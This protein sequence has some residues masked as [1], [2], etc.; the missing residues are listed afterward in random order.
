MLTFFW[1]IICMCQGVVKNTSGLIACRFFMGICKGEFVPGCAY[2]LSMYYKPHEFQQRFFLLWVAGLVAGAFGGLLAYALYHMHGL[3]RYSGWRWT[4]II[5]GLLS[6]VSALSAKFLI[7]DWPERAKFL[8]SEVKELLKELN[9]CDVGEGAGMDRLNGAAWRRIMS[10]WKIYYLG[11]TVSGYATVLFV[12]S[13]V[14]S[15]GY[16]DI[17]SQAHSI[18]TW[19]VTAVVTMM[20]SFLTDCW[21]HGYGFVIFGVVFASIG[22][23]ILLCQGPLSRGLNVHVRYMVVFFVTTGC[24]IAQPVAIVWMASNL[25][26][27][28]KRAV[29]LAIQVGDRNIGGII[30]SNIFNRDDAPLYTV[31]YGTSLAMIVFC[32]IM[33]TIFAAGLLIIENKKRDQRKRDDRLQIDEDVLND[34]SHDDPRFRFSL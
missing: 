25:R 5:E 31:G 8:S 7:A 23:I 15:L 21:R 19:A 18:P 3:G 13:I 14:N 1:G 26:W 33:S 20:V 12:P 2:L 6:I 17:E 28:Y 27:H 30:A 4:F 22:Y 24:Y 29:G 11:I 34:L 16:S 10:D 9:A 32:G